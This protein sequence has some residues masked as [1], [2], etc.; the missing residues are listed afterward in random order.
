MDN[1][2]QFEGR[3]TLEHEAREWLLRLDGDEPL[4]REEKQSLQVWMARSPAHQQELVRIAE[5]WDSANVLTEL[6]IPMH[7][8]ASDIRHRTAGSGFLASL[9]SQRGA[10]VVAMSVLLAVVLLRVA[11]QPVSLDASNGIYASAIGEVRMETLADGSVLQINTDSQVQVEY[12]EQVRKLRLL[13]GEAHF[14]VAHNQAWPFEVYAGNGRVKAV[15]TAFLVRLEA[16]RLN[17]IV[18]DGR[19]DLALN[20]PQEGTQPS[21]E[22]SAADAPLTT[23]GSLEQGQGASF[24][25]ELS[26]ESHH[27]LAQK[28]MQRQLSWREGYLVFEGE[29]LQVVVAELN[30]YLPQRVEIADQALNNILIGGRFKVDELE[31]LFDVLEA[32]FNIRVS[33]LD[34][35]RIQL[36]SK[37]DL[38]N[39]K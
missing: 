27:L 35:Q 17:V 25:A 36:F 38:N 7:Q 33:R 20:R 5:F 12:S 4:S 37:S 16:D 15:G 29:S 31:A 3:D 34:D 6:L 11:V 14:E 2:V 21:N 8:V 32:S 10:V 1:I 9:L 30:R 22:I 28:D 18:T 26:F 19:V 24:D 13:R 39:K 23:V